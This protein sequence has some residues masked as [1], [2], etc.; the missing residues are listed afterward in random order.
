MEL[1][2]VIYIIGYG[3][4]FFHHGIRS[5]EHGEFGPIV[6]GLFIISNG[7][8]FRHRRWAV[9][10]FIVCWLLLALALLPTV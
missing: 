4:E 10:G 3:V 8:L 9:V 2:T 5:W 1:I 7:L 6:T